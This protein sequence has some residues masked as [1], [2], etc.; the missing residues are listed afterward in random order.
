MMNNK[1]Y[2]HLLF[3]ITKMD[4][5]QFIEKRH[6][7][8]ILK[9]MEKYSKDKEMPNIIFHGKKGSGKVFI[10]KYLLNSLYKDDKVIKNYVLFVNCAEG[11]GIKFIRDELKFFAKTNI[12]NNLYIPF[13]SIVL[14]DS[15]KL[16]IDAQSALRRC[17]EL[18]SHTTR[19]F[20]LV[21]NKIK[22]LKP[23]VSRFCS[24]YVPYP[25]INGIPQNINYYNIQ[26]MPRTIKKNIDKNIDIIYNKYKNTPCSN[27]IFKDVNTLYENGVT[28]YDIIHY[29]EE[30][31][32]D[33]SK[34]YQLLIYFDKIRKDI[35]N[36]KILMFNILVFYSM[37]NVINLE[38]IGIM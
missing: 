9:K 26:L 34:K 8:E 18:F 6:H 33:N 30:N 36:E 17:I 37:R 32:N 22:L 5:N 21:E 14:Y 25:I 7:N 13:K 31:L 19:F 35:H 23:I 1:L 12:E 4:Y 10:M 3:I 27:H 16:T 24:I 2:K 38:N 20:M 15:D 29:L 11:K 28:G